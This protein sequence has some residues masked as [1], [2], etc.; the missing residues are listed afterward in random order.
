MLIL[1][2]Q[3]KKRVQ[4][5]VLENFDFCNQLHFHLLLIK[6]IPVFAMSCVLILETLQLFFILISST[7]F[8]TLLCTSREKRIK[9]INT[10]LMCNCGIILPYGINQ[11]SWWV[12][13]FC[14][15]FIWNQIS[16]FFFVFFFKL[17]LQIEVNQT[18]LT[19]GTASFPTEIARNSG[20]FRLFE[21][22]S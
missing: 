15:I 21:L 18:L 10:D 13:E 9:R 12:L 2:W 22:Y 4:C 17:L 7:F 6:I 14:S 5:S 11:L 16:P 19:S 8:L 1:M 20:F 3:N